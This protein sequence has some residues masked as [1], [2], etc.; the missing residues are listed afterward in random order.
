M[1]A[2]RLAAL[3]AA[4]LSAVAVVVP[5]AAAATP[6]DGLIACVENTKGGIEYWLENG[7]VRPVP[8]CKPLS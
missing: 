4:S 8:P 3:L 2:R 6:P 7:E 5:A 1:N